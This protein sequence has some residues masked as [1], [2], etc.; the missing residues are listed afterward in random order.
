MNEINQNAVQEKSAYNIALIV[1]IM[2]T[3]SFLRVLRQ[4]LASLLITLN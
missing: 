2:Q 3:L 1:Y 4:L